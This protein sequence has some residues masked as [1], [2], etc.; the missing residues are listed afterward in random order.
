[1][2]PVAGTVKVVSPSV[3]IKRRVFIGSSLEGL[4]HAT[5]VA[6]FLTDD[7][8]ECVLWNNFFEPGYL[9][10][11]GLENMLVECCAAVFI[12]T[13]DDKATIRGR[14][15]SV[16][17]ANI[18]LEFGL[19]AG[20]LGRHNIAICQ[21]GGTE[22]PSDLKGLTVIE[23]EPGETPAG[24]S[25]TYADEFRRRAG[26]SLARWSS[27]LLATAEMVARTDTVHGYTGRWTFDLWL[28]R[29]RGVEVSPKSFCQASG[30]MNLYLD[31]T[32]KAGYGSIFG[33][34]TFKLVNEREAATRAYQGV[35][36]FCHE[37]ANLVCDRQGGFKFTS[38]TYTIQKINA[39][40]PPLPEIG[41]LNDLP[42]PWPFTWELKPT[43]DPRTLTG[44]ICADN[45][46][47]TSGTIRAVKVIDYV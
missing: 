7:T 39:S 23:M 10:F 11:E 6:T 9:T 5:Q 27:T 16:P 38:R 1:M 28:D 32:G 35:L 4:E 21:Y 26:E 37:I 20:R 3:Q 24:A 19:V 33:Q 45:P 34:L 2:L 30:S 14:T 36:R 31:A 40:G 13:P 43:A 8:T 29:W 15:V 17:R 25:P 42:E 12:A 41:S 22:L 44:L 47:T 46:G 18:M